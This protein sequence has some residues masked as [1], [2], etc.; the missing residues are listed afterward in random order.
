MAQ[1]RAFQGIHPAPELVSGVVCVPYDAVDRDEASALTDRLPN[2]LLRVDRAEIDLPPETDLCSEGVYQKALANFLLL[3]SKGALVHESEP[4]MYLYRQRM[5]GHVQTGLAAVCHVEDYEKGAIKNS[6][7]PEPAKEEHRTR[8]LHAL[9][10]HTTPVLLAYRDEP[11]IQ[12]LV[13]PVLATPPLYHFRTPDQVEHTVWRIP[14]GEA[15]EKAFKKVGACYVIDSHHRAASA[16]RLCREMR[17]ANPRHTGT[18]EYNWFLGV[19]F[20]VSQLQI[21]PIHRIVKDLN[22]LSPEEF[23]KKIA[24]VFTCKPS[25]T[26]APDGPGQ[27]QMYLGDTWYSLSR[28]A[29]SADS[30][31]TPVQPDTHLLQDL[32]LSPI[33]E[34]TDPASSKRIEFLSGPRSTVELVRL[35][36]A[37]K[38]AVGFA[39]FPTSP[40]QV[41]A[42]ADAGQQLPFKSICFEPKLRSG[43]FIQTF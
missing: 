10:A 33:L 1:I 17:A 15:F 16:A 21:L 8:L 2:S 7:P 4:C 27:I 29:Q 24:S 43:L 25:R 41:L 22:D 37:G 3:Q 5:E 20:P 23:L 39:L 28:T 35:V 32:V 40:D 6:A 26:T 11:E 19:L 38:A 36:D 31:P 9:S 42:F 18:E 30:S 13:E 34:I 14:G 12:A